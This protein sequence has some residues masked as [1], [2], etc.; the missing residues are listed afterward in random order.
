MDV[1]PVRRGFLDGDAK[2]GDMKI[3][4]ATDDDRLQHVLTG[5]HGQIA[6]GTSRARITI[7]IGDGP[8]EVCE[9]HQAEVDIK[10]GTVTFTL[11]DPAPAVPRAKVL[12]R[13]V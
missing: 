1:P 10:N 8:A 13:A 5:V 11:D 3:T 12:G 6:F 2:M 9:I 7:A 4:L